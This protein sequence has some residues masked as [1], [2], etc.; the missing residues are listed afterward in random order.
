MSKIPSWD[1]KTNS[2]KY[3]DKPMHYG[4][5]KEWFAEGRRQAEIRKKRKKADEC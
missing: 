3:I 2:M 1:I 5:W 4:S